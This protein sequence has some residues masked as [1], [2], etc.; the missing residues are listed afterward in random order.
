MNSMSFGSD[1]VQEI[2]LDFLAD[3]DAKVSFEIMCLVRMTVEDDPT[4]RHDWCWSQHM[5]R[6]FVNIPGRLI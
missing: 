4:E 3:G 5:D 2:G 6:T 1:K